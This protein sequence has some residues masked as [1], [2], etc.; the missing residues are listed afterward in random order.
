LNTTHNSLAEALG[1]TH[2]V[3]CAVGAGGK[4]SLLHALARELRG[5]IALTASV[6]MQPPPTD[7][8]Q[9]TVIADDT[10]LRQAL[11]TA[12]RP[13]LTV[14]A[15][16]STK[17]GRLGGVEPA[18]IAWL[19][20]RAGFDYTLVKADGARGR[21]IKAPRAGEPA[22][23]PGAQRVLA[24]VSAAVLGR[25]LTAKVA[26]RPERLASLV[27]AAPGEPLAP[28]HLLR[29]ITSQRGSLQG[30]GASPVTIV[31]NQVDSSDQ[32]PPLAT[33]ARQAL[34]AQPGIDRIALTCLKDSPRLVAL[35]SRG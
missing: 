19:H 6:P 11:S 12:A 24:V 21:G 28:T 27:G 23:V 14:Y 32:V 3:V 22:I 35:F 17:P 10:R 34:A 8:A 29:L 15:A 1:A 2:G 20:A 9:A 13:G 33:M 16:P 25:S 18:T 30:C 26:H 5:R 7:L 31:I 4:K